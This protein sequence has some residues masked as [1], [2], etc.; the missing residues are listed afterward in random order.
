MKRRD[1]LVLFS[2]SGAALSSLFPLGALS[3]SK[4]N[5]SLEGVVV[6]DTNGYVEIDSPY[7]LKN[8]DL[9]SIDSGK[10]NLN[11]S[12]L[13]KNSRSCF[14]E[15]FQVQIMDLDDGLDE[16]D[17]K[18]WITHDFDR[19]VVDFFV[20]NTENSIV[21][22]ENHERLSGKPTKVGFCVDLNS[23]DFESTDSLNDYFDN[24]KFNINI[25]KNPE[26]ENG[27][28]R[29]DS[30]ESLV[31]YEWSEAEEK[32]I[33]EDSVK[34]DNIELLENSVK[35]DEEDE[36]IEVKF[37]SNYCS[38][39]VVVQAGLSG[40]PGSGRERVLQHNNAGPGTIT[41]TSVNSDVSTHAISHIE[42][43]CEY[44]NN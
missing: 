41:V 32:F 30:K 8:S 4:I 19:D 44:P 3:K 33:F 12:R 18:L 11:L 20:Y 38:I 1:L 10:L 40:G 17:Y 42:F 25:E 35:K 28:I 2:I 5:R 29:C 36:P 24:G 31:K 39:D 7:S 6:E 9:V 16:S 23:L 26:M 37:N 22:I 43:Y 21:G 14:P 13:N 34:D 15:L 27:C